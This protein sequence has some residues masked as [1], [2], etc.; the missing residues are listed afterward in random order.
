MDDPSSNGHLLTTPFLVT[1]DDRASATLD[2]LFAQDTNQERR[3]WQWQLVAGAALVLAVGSM[4]LAYVGWFTRPEVLPFVQLVQ[5]DEEKKAHMI[6]TAMRVEAY[7][8]QEGEWR[9]MLAEWVLYFRWRGIDKPQAQQA[10]EW[11][12]MFSCGM[13]R[14]QL[15]KYVEVE[16]PMEL[17]G[18]KK[19]QIALTNIFR[20]DMPH[21]WT[22]LWNELETTGPYQPIETQNSGTFTVGRRKVTTASMRMHNPLGLCVN[23]FHYGEANTEGKR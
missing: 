22:V 10:W 1:V 18:V 15:E 16:K 12:D 14:T 13:A 21:A 17:L 19:R 6:D 20:S 23:G 3:A 4:G 5:V 7:T 8:P 2:A 11:L 9:R